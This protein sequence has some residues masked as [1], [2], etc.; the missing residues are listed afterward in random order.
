MQLLRE[1]LPGVV[2]GV[3]ILQRL[4]NVAD[5]FHEMERYGLQ[6][7]DPLRL[8]EHMGKEIL[9]CAHTI[10]V[11]V[12]VPKKLRIVSAQLVKVKRATENAIAD[13]LNCSRKAGA[14]AWSD[15][16]VSALF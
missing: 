13:V 3:A 8:P 5:L 10:N 9:E 15:I 4:R 6:R 14:E 1:W 2:V 16:L 7:E 12:G 11:L